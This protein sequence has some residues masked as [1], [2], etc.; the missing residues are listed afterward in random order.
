MELN[1]LKDTVYS[2]WPVKQNELPSIIQPYWSYIDEIAIEAGILF[3]GSRLIIPK[4]MQ[5][6]IMKK[7]HAAHQ[8][9]EKTKL[10]ARSCVFWM[11]LNNDIDNITKSCG[12]CQKYMSSQTKEPLIQTEVPPRPWHTIG[13]D[14]FFLNG[15]EY[16]LVSDYY[17]KY[18]FV[19]KIPKSQSTSQTVVNLM[20]EFF[21]EHGIPMTVRSDNGPHYSGQAFKQFA[22]DYGF[23]HNT[24]SHT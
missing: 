11:N 2:G 7:L 8:G 1:T 21:G 13:T 9:A 24:S 3:K 5:S 22:I 4:A 15:D 17:S 19:R 18:S 23:T 10:R 12:I 20:K 6:E 14:L 16:L